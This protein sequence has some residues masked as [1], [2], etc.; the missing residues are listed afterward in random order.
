MKILILGNMGYVGPLVVERLR[1]SYPISTIIGFDTGFFASCL[2]NADFLPERKLDAQY[3]GDV[4]RFPESLLQGVDVVIN[5]AA[6]SNDPMGTQFEKVTKE[7]NHLA[8]IEIA[9][10]AKEA[11]VKNFVFASSCSIYGANPGKA[12]EISDVNPLTAYARSKIY[13]EKELR[14]LADDNFTV[15]CLRFATA[16]G[17]SPRL[18]L[19]LVLNDFVACALSSKKITILSDGTPWRP[20]IN[21]KDMA[22]AIDWAITRSNSVG[23]FLAI[24]IGSEAWNYQV[25]E[26]AENVASEIPEVRISVN[27]DAP[28]DRRSYQVDF[29]LFEI[30]APKHQPQC[31]LL[32]TIKE[33]RIGLES[34]NFTDAAF[35]D[36]KLMRLKVL[37]TLQTQE[38][39]DKNLRW[40]FEEQ[41][42]MS[43]L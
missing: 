2:T 18:R 1:M 15:T 32:T 28:V 9:K 10:R 20:L 3:F 38:Q 12:T 7:V 22:L 35:R 11:G 31:D 30:L 36:S 16:C 33:L 4:R 41:L 26:L 17:M 14:P 5:L 29:S 40:N 23:N 25:K 13:T 42:L 24:N 43:T 27:A 19:D 34:M 39:L 8:G 37:T 6:I 21:V